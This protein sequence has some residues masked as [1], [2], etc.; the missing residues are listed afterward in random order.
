L[1]S[2]L[3]SPIPT[4]YPSDLHSTKWTACN[5]AGRLSPCAFFARSHFGRGW[6]T[7]KQLFHTPE[8]I[9]FL[10]LLFLIQYCN[11]AFP[12]SLGIEIPCHQNSTTFLTMHEDD[13]SSE[14]H[15][16][17]SENLKSHTVL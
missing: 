3:L 6:R 13:N 17:C 9:T 7:S 10:R 2:L 12:R 5:K 15:T 14:L 8:L 1:C 4:Q 11:L 16:R